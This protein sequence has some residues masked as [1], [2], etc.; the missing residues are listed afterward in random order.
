[1]G[2]E[3]WGVLTPPPPPHFHH[4]FSKKTHREKIWEGGSKEK[5]NVVRSLI[6]G[7][8]KKIQDCNSLC[9]MVGNISILTPQNFFQEEKFFIPGL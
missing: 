8:K 5:N 7:Q 9:V 4:F 3:A 6:G 2:K 1:L